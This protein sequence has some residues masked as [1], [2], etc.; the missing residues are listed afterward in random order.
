MLLKNS[1]RPN[2]FLDAAFNHL[3]PKNTPLFTVE[4][5]TIPSFCLFP[6]SKRWKAASKNLFGRTLSIGVGESV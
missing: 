6:P 4:V 3:D 5:L 1:V 2:K